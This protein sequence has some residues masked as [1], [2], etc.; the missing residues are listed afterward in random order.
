M[1]RRGTRALDK[2]PRFAKIILLL[3]YDE[4]FSN[5]KNKRTRLTPQVLFLKGYEAAPK[6][7]FDYSLK[8]CETKFKRVMKGPSKFNKGQ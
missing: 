4:Y 1:Y 8:P 2:S 7:V 3:N 5:S 6:A